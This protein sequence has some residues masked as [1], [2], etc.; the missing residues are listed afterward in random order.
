MARSV[1]EQVAEQTNADDPPDWEV[2]LDDY[3]GVR[4]RVSG[5]LVAVEDRL[6]PAWLE[7]ESDADV[8]NP[9]T[10]ARIEVR[11]G[12]PR[13][14]QLG[15]RSLPGQPEVLQKHLRATQVAS[16]LDLFAGFTFRLN[17]A[18]R[19]VEFSVDPDTEF[20]IETRNFLAGL[21]QSP[22]NRRITSEFLQRVAEVYR[23][24]IAH[25]P[26]QAVAK[27]FGVK[28]RQAS[29]YV[30]K[31]RQRGFLPPTKQGRKKA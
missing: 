22:G 11:D 13:L 16:L 10:S 23:D 20:S 21:R 24:N 18:Q 28:P 17:E 30:D 2:E 19:L 26:T 3:E 15:W 31:A 9:S 29:V 14:V 12:V 7:L 25:A 4:I 5:R 1:A 6:M 8:D 27:R